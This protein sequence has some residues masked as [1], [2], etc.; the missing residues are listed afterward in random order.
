[1]FSACT[2]T[3]LMVINGDGVVQIEVA[4]VAPGHHDQL[5]LVVAEGD[6]I[7]LT[8][9]LGE[10]ENVPEVTELICSKY[11][12]ICESNGR[13]YLRLARELAQAHPL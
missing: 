6:T 7:L 3:N 13:Y 9:V 4:V 8:I 11:G 2:K 12:I 1:M 10:E 5:C